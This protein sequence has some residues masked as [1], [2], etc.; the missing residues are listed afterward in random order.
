M[1]VARTLV[2]VA[3][4]IAAEATSFNSSATMVLSPERGFRMQIDTFPD[5]DGVREGLAQC[6]K[7]NLTVSLTYCYIT[8]YWNVSQIPA[9]FIDEL[10][11]GFAQMR[12][13]GVK[14]ILI[15]SYMDGKANFSKDVEPFH[16]ETIYSHMAQLAPTIHA[17]A[18]VLHALQAG[19]LGNAGEWAHDIHNLT[20]NATGL[21]GLMARE[22]FAFLPSDRFVLQRKPTMKRN[23]LSTELPP[24]DGLLFAEKWNRPFALAG[25]GQEPASRIGFYNAAFQST[26][27][28]GGEKAYGT[29]GCPDEMY[30]SR[31]TPFVAMDGECYY[32][33]PWPSKG[34]LLVDG[35][36]AAL[37]HRR[38]HFTTFSMHNSF[39]P[40]DTEQSPTPKNKSINVWMQTP[41]DLDFVA[42][43]KLP[44]SPAYAAAAQ[45]KGRTVF[46]YIRDHLGYRI[47]LVS[48]A[49]APDLSS[50]NIS[51]VNYGFSRPLYAR[52]VSVVVLDAAGDVVHAK[53][54]EG[55]DVRE[56]QPH[57][58]GDPLF[59]PL[60]H[61]LRVGPLDFAPAGGT[62]YRVG[63]YLPDARGNGSAFAM[64]FAN[65]QGWV[66]PGVNVIGSWDPPMR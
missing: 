4:A 29:P 9:S 17:N 48:A 7:Y 58:V 23:L 8:K 47:E 39:W 50:V 18:D 38:H 12:Q 24:A 20:G 1:A 54:L 55:V 52:P 43:H 14:S 45:D 46:E 19:W 3:C 64:R 61:T 60:V 11:A 5:A 36:A 15:F 56:W 59:T 65:A 62:Y 16:F 34:R 41:L 51:L 57:V 30:V 33:T 13:A 44:I 27:D 63:L 49:I 25:S 26:T 22:L 6:A 40:L 32:G 66:D 53:R 28:D 31:E 10:D 21:A 37:R 42:L 35:H 2:L